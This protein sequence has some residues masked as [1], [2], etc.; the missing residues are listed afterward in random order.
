[1]LTIY[2]KLP[3]IN[4]RKVVWTCAEIGIPFALEEWGAGFRPTSEPGFLAMNPNGMVPVIR[5][6][7]LVLWESNTICR[8][9]AGRHGRSDLLPADLARRALVEQWMDWQ[10]GDF[11]NSWRYAF[12]ALVRRHTDHTDPRAIAA[13]V[14]GWNR[15]MAILNAQL[16]K[17]GP[18]VAG[19]DFTLA[20]IVL[21]LSVHRWL[22]SPID[23]PGLAAVAD[24]YSRLRQRESF[25]PLQEHV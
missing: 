1:M 11:N 6:G 20:D 9:L 3:S 12:L 25:L 23:R 8:Y 10:G 7:D 16:E 22:R 15:H 24:Y 4:V 2:G 5:D 18:Y 21:G 17:T 13:G 14:E 19:N